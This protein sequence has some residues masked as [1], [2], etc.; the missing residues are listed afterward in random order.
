[1][2][3]NLANKIDYELITDLK[4]LQGLV[5]QWQEAKFLAIDTEFIRTCTFLAQPGLIQIADTQGVYLIDPAAITDL[6]LLVDILENPNII[7][8]MHS[9]SE[10]VDL[11]FHSVGAQITRVFDTQIAAA[12]L[13]FGPALGYQNLVSE[14]LSIDL[15]KGETRSDWLQ[16]PL[17]Q[18]QLHY[19]ALDVIY[20]LKLYHELQPRLQKAHYW[21]ALFDETQL[22][23][24]QVFS[25]WQTPELAYLKLRGACE[26]DEQS[27]RLLQSLVIWR[28]ATAFKENI[29]KP[30]VFN[31]A[32]LI[33][34]ARLKPFV[35]ADLKKIKGI[36]GKSIRQFSERLLA[37]IDGFTYE[38]TTEFAMIDGPV[39]A[40]ELVI[41]R[42]LKSEVAKVS[43]ETKIPAQ[44][45]GSR[46]M[47]ENLVIHCSRLSNKDF[48]L[49]YKGWREKL[50]G[51][52]FRHIL[53]EPS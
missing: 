25:A 39:K 17:T 19:A 20:L 1:M 51:N 50:M 26:L 21:D 10:D 43:N 42:R 5:I 22:L 48:T 7:K 36:Q 15:D 33:E 3:D 49:E 16:R 37:E 47:L 34:I 27:Q 9:M 41:Y 46:K 8:I 13:G 29:P 6:S 12:F 44:L 23:I 40:G 4:R 18:S 2:D 32:S 35:S 38:P 45:L 31:D 53:F 28:D 30:W 52:R 11:L 24:S 14:V